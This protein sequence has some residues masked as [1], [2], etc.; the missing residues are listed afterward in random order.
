MFKVDDYYFWQLPIVN[1]GAHFCTTLY[2]LYYLPSTTVKLNMC[3]LIL[4]LHVSPML[5]FFRHTRRLQVAA[6]RLPVGPRYNKTNGSS[7]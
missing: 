1:K 4:R 2:V 5:T 6:R 7:E 3:D